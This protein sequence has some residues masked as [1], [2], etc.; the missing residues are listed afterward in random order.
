[1][2]TCIIH[3][4]AKCIINLIRECKGKRPLG[5]TGHGWTDT[6]IMEVRV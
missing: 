6:I 5:R 3:G 1:M 2:R 4:V